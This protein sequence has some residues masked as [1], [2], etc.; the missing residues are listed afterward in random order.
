MSNK[1]D[2]Q[3]QAIAKELANANGHADD[4]PWEIAGG[5][6][7]PAWVMYVSEATNA[8]KAAKI[9]AKIKIDK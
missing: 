1:I 5:A 6:F 4:W 7:V 9:S 8:I 2:P 3:T